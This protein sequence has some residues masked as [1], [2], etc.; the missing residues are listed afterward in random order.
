MKI[1]LDECLDQR[2]AGEIR[3]HTMKTVSD[4]GWKG[5]TNG[6]LLSLAEKEFDAF[7]T[8]D[9]NLPFQQHLAPLKIAVSI[10]KTSSNKFSDLKTLIPKIMTELPKARRGQAT[11]ISV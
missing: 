3:G 4:M 11:T 8:V 1:L 10:L 9:Q 5:I 7:V 6:E 2:L